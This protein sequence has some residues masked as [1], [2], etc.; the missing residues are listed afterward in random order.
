MRFLKK[1]NEIMD[2]VLIVTLAVAFTIFLAFF[3]AKVRF[4]EEDFKQNSAEDYYARSGIVTT[5]DRETDTVV[6]IDS[7][8]YVWSFRGC[9]DWESGDLIAC[10]MN[11]RG[12]DEVFDDE[13]VNARYQARMEKMKTLGED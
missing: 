6:W 1:A 2:V 8:G 3:I 4:I 12:T 11:D 10:V 5:V 13:I 9:E 7:V